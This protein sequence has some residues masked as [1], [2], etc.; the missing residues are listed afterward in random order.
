MAIENQIG[1]L[2]VEIERFGC[3]EKATGAIVA[4]EQIHRDVKHH[5]IGRWD[6][7]N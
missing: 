6:S 2:H 1:R 5:G 4:V 3:I 7:P